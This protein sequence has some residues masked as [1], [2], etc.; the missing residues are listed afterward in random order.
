MKGL[1]EGGYVH[2]V[3]AEVFWVV[4]DGFVNVVVHDGFQYGI[5][6]EQPPTNHI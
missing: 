6:M 5:A 4:S 1:R 2:L 3:S